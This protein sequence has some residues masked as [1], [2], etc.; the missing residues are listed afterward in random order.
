MIKLEGAQA[1]QYV[2]QAYET[3]WAGIIKVSPQHGPKMRQ[4]FTKK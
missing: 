3:G 2:D 4:L 1:K